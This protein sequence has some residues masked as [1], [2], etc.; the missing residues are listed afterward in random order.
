MDTMGGKIVIG[1]LIVSFIMINGCL[2]E[3][4]SQSFSIYDEKA[5]NSPILKIFG[6]ANVTATVNTIKD[7]TID[8][9]IDKIENHVFLESEEKLIVDGDEIIIHATGIGEETDWNTKLLSANTQ[10]YSEIRC[11]DG[12]ISSKEQF[13]K[14][15]CFWEI[16]EEDIK[17]L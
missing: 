1:L 4:N 13:T 6:K 11:L 16:N 8:I 14:E 9:R 12:R 15:K 10:F 2:Q 3:R 7:Q 17:I 5:D